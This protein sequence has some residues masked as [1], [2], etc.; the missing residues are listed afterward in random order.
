MLVA[1]GGCVGSHVM[2]RWCRL[3]S[4]LLMLPCACCV[5]MCLALLLHTVLRTGISAPPKQL[6]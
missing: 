6:Q 1:A 2:P 3:G 5:G 4:S